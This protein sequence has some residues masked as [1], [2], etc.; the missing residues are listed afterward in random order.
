MKKYSI[1][2]PTFLLLLLIA[3]SLGSCNK[4]INDQPVT[5]LTTANAYTTASDMENVLAGC[6]NTFYG[7]DYYQWENVMLSDV[8]SDNAYPGGGN[9]E[10]FLD[11]DR[12]ILPPSNTHNSAHWRALFNG[13]A[14]CNILL[15]KINGVSDPAL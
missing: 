4:F 8:R 6:Y 7:S 3:V 5:S 14:R 10:T 12:F 1:N 13:I 15:D 2:L 11:Y 9:E